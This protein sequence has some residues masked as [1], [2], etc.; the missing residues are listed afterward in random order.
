MYKYVVMVLGIIL[1]INCSK[2]YRNDLSDDYFRTDVEFL[3]FKAPL[4][5]ECDII[6]REDN[7]VKEYE[8]REI[9]SPT[10]LG[11]NNWVV[12]YF[13]DKTNYNIFICKINHTYKAFFYKTDAI[14]AESDVLKIHPDKVEANVPEKMFKS[15]YSWDYSK[16]MMKSYNKIIIDFSNDVLCLDFFNAIKVIE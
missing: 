2:K 8:L 3:N 11:S 7:T 12:R 13:K 14:I 1:L 5:I 4:R 6:L 16:F 9:P 15:F 10:K